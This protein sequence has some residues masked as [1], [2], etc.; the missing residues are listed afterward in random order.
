MKEQVKQKYGTIKAHVKENKTAYITG[1]TCLVIGV[2]GGTAYAK[3]G[4]ISQVVKQN[5]VLCWRPQQNVVQVAFQERST[6]S[7]PIVNKTT[8]A[9]YGSVHEAAR[10]TGIDRSLI[11]KN[12][13]GHIPDAKGQVFEAIDVA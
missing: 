7:K 2:L 1:A 9:A 8:N 5:N 12:I 10:Q 3:R 11:S 4:E 13:N 6:P